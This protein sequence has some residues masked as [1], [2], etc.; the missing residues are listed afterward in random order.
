[1]L[2]P[3]Q[4]IRQISKIAHD[5]DLALACVIHSDTDFSL[6]VCSGIEPEACAALI[7][8]ISQEI[9]GLTRFNDN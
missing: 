7:G 6:H 5:N 8:E 1:M 9:M 2:T 3:D 4:A